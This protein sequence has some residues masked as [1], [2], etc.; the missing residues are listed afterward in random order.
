MQNTSSRGMVEP[1]GVAGHCVGCDDVHIL[2]SYVVTHHGATE[3]EIV[4]YC[5]DC[6]D[7]AA[8]DWNGETAEIRPCA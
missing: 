8:I 1:D 6:A 2:R 4:R 3:P 7:L 5:D